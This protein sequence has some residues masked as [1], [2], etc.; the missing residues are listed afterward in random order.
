M[1]RHLRFRH[2]QILWWRRSR[3]LCVSALKL[4]DWID[5]ILNFIAVVASVLAVHQGVQ[6]LALNGRSR[7]AVVTLVLGVACCIGLAS[8]NYVKFHILTETLATLQN[9]KLKA[10]PLEEWSP[11]LSGKQ[12][13][14]IG[15]MVSR[16]EY[17]H[18]GKLTT[19]QDQN[20]ISRQF[21]PSQ[22]DISER[23]LSVTNLTKIQLLAQ[24][25]LNDAV[26][27]FLWAL[28]AAMFG[29]YSGRK[30]RNDR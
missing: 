25:R 28:I 30:L 24:A 6:L 2:L 3:H 11:L 12:N 16:N 7:S 13:E 14:D 26:A 18:T 15:L 8:I 21:S 19:Y 29:W 1:N 5:Y 17:F 9:Y 23:E 27:M 4:M 10:P 22:A 20:K